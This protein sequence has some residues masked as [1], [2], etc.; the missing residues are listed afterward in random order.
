MLWSTDRELRLLTF[1]TTGK[2]A[3]RT[4]PGWRNQSIDHLLGFDPSVDRVREAHHKALEGLDSAFDQSWTGRVYHLYVAP[5]YDAEGRIDGCLGF[6]QDLADFHRAE[7]ALRASEARYRVISEL[8]GTYA[9]S[10]RLEPDG[11][12]ILEWVIGDFVQIT[13][14]PLEE[15]KAL[16]G[17]LTLVHPADRHLA[18]KRTERL[19]A[20]YPHVSEFRIITRSGA[21][22]WLRDY[23]RPVRDER[24]QG[25]V[26]FYGTAQDVTDRKQAEQALRESEERFRLAF[27]EG[28]LGMV[29]LNREGAVLQANRAMSHFLG[30]LP[31]E[32]AGRTF[33]TLMPREESLAA[34]TVLRGIICG[35]RERHCWENRYLRQD[36]MQVWGRTTV[37]PLGDEER[38]ILGALAMVEDITARKHTEE[39]LRRAERLASIGTL[40][41]GIAHEINNPLGAITLSVD[42]VALSADQENRDEIVELA[43]N[44]IRASALRCGRIVK[45]VL[46]FARDEVSQK[47]EGD[48]AEVARRARDMARSFAAGKDIRLRL[49]AE[50]SLPAVMMNA[51]EMTQVCVNLISNAVQAS[52]PGG[53][54][55]VRLGSAGSSVRLEVADEGHGIPAEEIDHIFD[56]FFTSRPNEGGTGLGLSITYGI[57]QQHGGTIDVDSVPGRGTVVSIALPTSEA[58]SP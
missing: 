22:R 8:T 20:G 34:T 19:L 42:A 3:F 52:R 25:T 38:K 15:I 55:V 30:C 16:G 51:T 58:A 6:A 37:T 1:W 47:L 48:L 49:E 12:L 54:V 28:P 41:A 44:N 11:T 36:G 26:R 5:K 46:Q 53:T 57:V 45:S 14:Y 50:D 39:A 4:P 33:E 17:P 9:Y 18:A 27:E 7:D 24:E 56:P 43:M 29:V 2:V 10:T 35:T 32:L 13:G 23:G 31:R 21:T 40:A